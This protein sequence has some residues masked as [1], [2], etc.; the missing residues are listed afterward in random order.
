MGEYGTFI[1]S[2]NGGVNWNVSNKTS[3]LTGRFDSYFIFNQSTYFV[4]TSDAKLIKTVDY[5]KNWSVLYDFH[6][7]YT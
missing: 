7:Y 4:G 1:S 6:L 5:G 2:T 3:G